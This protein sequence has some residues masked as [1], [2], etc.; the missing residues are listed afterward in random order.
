MRQ[1]DLNVLAGKLTLQNI[2]NH[3]HECW[4]LNCIL[5]VIDP[6]LLSTENMTTPSGC[7]CF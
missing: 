2:K 4:V 3:L 6:K 5:E 7:Q 1:N